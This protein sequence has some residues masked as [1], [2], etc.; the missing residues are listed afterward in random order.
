MHDMLNEED[1]HSGNK[2]Y[3]RIT[4]EQANVEE[5]LLGISKVLS[6]SAS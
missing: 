6:P 3:A 4:R 1:E 5:R 2:T